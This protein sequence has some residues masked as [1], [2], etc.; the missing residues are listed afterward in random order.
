MEAP[1]RDRT[2][3]TFGDSPFV[4]TYLPKV[5]KIASEIAFP[6]RITSC[7]LDFAELLFPEVMSADEYKNG[8]R[9]L[10]WSQLKHVAYPDSRY[11]FD[12]AEFIA[13]F[14]GS[15]SAIRRLQE[16]PGYQNAKTVFIAP[17]NC[18]E[19]LRLTALEQ[20]KRVLTTTY[21][22]RRGF[23]YLD[24]AH[25]PSALHRYAATLDGM[26]KVARPVKL[27]DMTA[28][29]LTV[30][31]LVT[32][33]GAINSNG[34][35]YGKGHG[36]FDCEWGI[37]YALQRVTEH[38]PVATVAHD[39]QVL[40]QDFKRADFDTVSDFVVTPTRLVHVPNVR[41]PTG[42]ILWTQL[43]ATM[44]KSIPPLQELLALQRAKQNPEIAA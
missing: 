5:P 1:C 39:C 11:H 43:D 9:E 23:W 4:L 8:I 10:V 25:I 18:L 37:L 19:E 42:G 38:T 21:G 31:F 12:F 13:D 36:F 33:T 16:I 40:Y 35:R 29:D 15:L 28:M 26:E 3:L 34:V 22:I 6:S 27:V 24:P 30:D 14:C 44:L 17:D 32:G 20:G 2:A 7:F 41:K